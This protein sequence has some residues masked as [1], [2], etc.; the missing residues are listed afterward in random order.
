M[1]RAFGVQR[2]VSR[3][4][5]TRRTVLGMG[6]AA[7]AAGMVGLPKVT[8]AKSAQSVPRAKNI[9]FLV[10]DGM[11]AAVETMLDHYLQRVE[12]RESAWRQL[13]RTPGAVN[14]FMDCRSLNSMVT[15]SAA[16]GSAWGSGVHCWN[17][18]INTLAD[19]TEL[20]TIFDLLREQGAKTGLVT[21]ATVTHATPASFAVAVPGRGDES[22]IAAD[23]LT[24]DI[25]VIA[26]GG[27]RFFAGD[28]RSDGRDLYAEFAN[29][30]YTICRN[31][32]EM[33]G[34]QSG[35]ML[36]IFSD[37]HIPYEIDRVNQPELTNNV[38][39]LA[40]MTRKAISLLQ[41]SGDGFILQVEAARVDHAAHGN[42]IAGL[43]Y[44]QYAFEEAIRVAWEFAEQDGETLIVVTSDHGNANPGLDY[45]YGD[46]GQ[47]YG[48][49][50]GLSR[51][52]ASFEGIGNELRGVN[53]AARAKEVFES[54][55]A[56][57]ITDA[58][59][60]MIYQTAAHNNN[61]LSEFRLH[62]G[63]SA[64]AGHVIANHLRIGWI[65]GNH[66]SDHTMLTAW[67]PG[68][69]QFQ[70]LVQNI[71][72]FG[73]L[74]ATR[75]ISFENPSLTFEEAARIRTARMEQE[76]NAQ[77]ANHWI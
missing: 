62:G 30:G 7:A 42:C 61:P 8:F 45:S 17:G 22:G 59:A 64:I 12:G 65:S 3:S 67:G 11:S 13:S 4:N 27:N 34:V 33:N 29:A 5:V 53:S 10:S 18:Q 66:T 32:A 23:Y 43:H 52:S 37:S 49:I 31:T 55:T 40:E 57:E 14:G 50:E 39:S 71:E 15:D 74:L 54:F 56:L 21:T 46:Y 26:G 38:P 16:A 47:P 35:R 6:A 20:R 28:L 41:G 68:A 72:V 69:D 19:G 1:Q 24:K 70:G 75:E 25:D 9:I 48:G 63:I 44:D 36:A 51:F 2:F 73:K 58:E 77:L 76:L 60:E